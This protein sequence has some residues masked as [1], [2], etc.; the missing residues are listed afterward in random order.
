MERVLEQSQKNRVTME[1][2]NTTERIRYRFIG[3]VQHR[4]FRYACVVCAEKAGVSGWVRNE[5]NGTVT[6]E[7]QGTPEAHLAFVRRLTQLVTGFG[8]TWSVGSEKRVDVVEQEKGFSVR[9]Y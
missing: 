4:G 3:H 5:R 6:A 1:F 2:P 8:N 7:A 9:R